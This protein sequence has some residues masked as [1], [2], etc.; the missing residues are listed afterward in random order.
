[1][2]EILNLVLHSEKQFIIQLNKLKENPILF[3]IILNSQVKI[4][5]TEIIFRTLS[6]YLSDTWNFDSKKLIFKLNE[7]LGLY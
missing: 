3:C 5:K 2:E 6:K 1:M 7:N 4:L